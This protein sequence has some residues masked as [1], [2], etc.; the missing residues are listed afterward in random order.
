M[1]T[2]MR[3]ELESSPVLCETLLKL[4]LV[5]LTGRAGAFSAA[6]IIQEYFN[7]LLEA[8]IEKKGVEYDDHLVHDIISHNLHHSAHIKLNLQ[9][10]VGI[11]QQS[12]KHSV[13]GLNA[14]EKI[15]L[16]VYHDSEL[17]YHQLGHVY[18]DKAKN[19]F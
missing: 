6:D 10:G 9:M 8:I 3:L 1:E 12:R 14:K 19:M 11:E 2:V 16:Q 18:D 4:T 13:P 15:L 5:N 17:Y 7:C